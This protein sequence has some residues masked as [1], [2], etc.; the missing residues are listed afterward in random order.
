[1]H[2][3]VDAVLRLLQ[4]RAPVV[5]TV[6]SEGPEP[7][8][9]PDERG[10]DRRVPLR[11]GVLPGA[12]AQRRRASRG[13]PRG[14]KGSDPRGLTLALRSQDVRPRRVGLRAIYGMGLTPSLGRS[15]RGLT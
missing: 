6:G 11:V 13:I 10:A 15:G 9:D 12:P 7:R 3:L 4:A 8:W 5:G 14:L 1:V 2:L